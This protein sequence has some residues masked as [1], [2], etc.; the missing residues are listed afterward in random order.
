MCVKWRVSA[1]P[2]DGKFGFVLRQMA[3]LKP[4]LLFALG[5]NHAEGRESFNAKAQSR[6]DAKRM[7]NLKIRATKR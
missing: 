4:G 2:H 1:A 3:G 5:R 7:L 6:K